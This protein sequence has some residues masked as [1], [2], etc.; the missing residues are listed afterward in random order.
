[1][2]LSRIQLRFNNLRPEMLEKWNSARPYASHQWLWQ[3]FPEQE[4]RQFLF[5]EEPHGGFFMLSAIPPL[6]HHSLFLIET[7][8]FNPQLTNGLELDFQLRANPVIT[9]NGKRSDVMMNAKYQA[10]ANDV[11]QE[12]WWELQQQAAQAWLEKQGQQ[13]GF[14]LLTE[15]TDDFSRWA[16]TEYSEMQAQCGCVQAYQQHRF[17]RN[18]QDK[19]IAFSSVDFSGTLCV[20]DASLFEQALFFGLGKSRALGCGMLMVKRKR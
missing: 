15:A 10:K 1:M 3:L 9:R 8:P 17:V 6:L 20:T 12:R 11:A 18:D 4:S 2:Y 16:G 19:P 7:K 5:R 14:R 13:H